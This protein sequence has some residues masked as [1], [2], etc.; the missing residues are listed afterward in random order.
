[1]YT[2]T[3]E[4]HGVYIVDTFD[5]LRVAPL[6]LFAIIDGRVPHTWAVSMS[7]AE[8]AVF[9]APIEASRVTFADEVD[10]QEEEAL[11]VFNSL[12]VRQKRRPDLPGSSDPSERATDASG[13][14]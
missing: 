2:S 13:L 14:G 4:S 6:A 5:R 8:E 1:V 12:L 3:A 9:I 7:S 11:A 10:E